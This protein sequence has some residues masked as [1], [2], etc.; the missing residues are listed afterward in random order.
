[1]FVCFDT[2]GLEIMSACSHAL[3]GV[4][5]LCLLHWQV[6]IVSQLQYESHCID[7][8]ETGILPAHPTLVMQHNLNGVD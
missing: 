6:D 8:T 1:M 2:P 3:Y 5:I 4:L 7:D